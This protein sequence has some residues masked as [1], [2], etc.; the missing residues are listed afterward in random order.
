MKRVGF[1]INFDFLKWL[2]GT[3]VIKNLINCI[4]LYSKNE[5]EPILIIKKNLSQQ[6]KKEFK[7]IKLLKTNFFQ[8]QNFFTRIYNKFLIFVFGKSKKYDDFS[9][10]CTN[11]EEE[12]SLVWVKS[13]TPY[14]LPNP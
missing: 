12:L 13:N 6:E 14:L 5:I 3:Y 11:V 2:G 9:L 4:N 8:N 7:N 1:L 10:I